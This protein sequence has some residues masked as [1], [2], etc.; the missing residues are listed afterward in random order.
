MAE[1]GSGVGYSSGP[2]IGGL[3]YEVY[4]DVGNN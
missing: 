1:V 2:V 3:L 4:I